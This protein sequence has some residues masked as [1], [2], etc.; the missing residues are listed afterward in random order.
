MA[1]VAERSNAVIS[2]TE[3]VYLCIMYHC[4]VCLPCLT[5]SYCLISLFP[6]GLCAFVGRRS[7]CMRYHQ[8][9]HLF[10]Q[11][12][13]KTKVPN[14]TPVT[15]NK[16]NTIARWL[17][18]KNVSIIVEYNSVSLFDHYQGIIHFEIGACNYFK[19]VSD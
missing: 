13:F 15:N 12:V 17:C 6:L 8:H 14:I 5:C 11:L 4:L 1:F 10:T 16:T 3:T 18:C 2:L 7:L 19:L 9:D